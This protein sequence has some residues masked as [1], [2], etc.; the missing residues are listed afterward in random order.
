LPYLCFY[1]AADNIGEFWRLRQA[2]SEDP[3]L[4][5]VDVL[6]SNWKLLQ[7]ILQQT[8]HVL[9]HMFVG[10]WPKKKDEM[11]AYNLRKLIVAFDTIE[12]PVR[13][14]KRILVK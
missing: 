6:E 11:P 3:L 12:D 8:R 1:D 5:A 9:I 4:D 14:M 10:F 2:S 7:N 13:A